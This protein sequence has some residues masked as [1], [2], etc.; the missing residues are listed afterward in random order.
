MLISA[1]LD[2]DE[3]EDT[4]MQAQPYLFFDGTCDEALDFY[5]KAVGAKVGMRMYF[6]DAPDQAM[7]KPEA[8]DKVMHAAVTIGDSTLLA[9]DGHCGGAPKFD[10]FSISLTAGS[11]AE[12][13]KCFAALAEGGTV[14]MPL[15]KTFFAG[16]FGMLKDK[17]GVGWMVLAEPMGG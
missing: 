17:F 14:Q 8:R 11:K 16:A 2:N 6:R 5:T 9:S 10:G 1:Y 4:A 7:V 15:D 3:P 12:A 13:E